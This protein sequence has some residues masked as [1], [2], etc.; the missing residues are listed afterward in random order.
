MKSIIPE[1]PNYAKELVVV[2]FLSVLFGMVE[3]VGWYRPIR[4]VIEF[5]GVPINSAQVRFV[6]AI[7]TPGQYLVQSF[8]QAEKTKQLEENYAAALSQ[9]SELEKLRQEN[10]ALRSL[11]ENSDRTL[12]SRKITSPLIS[13][14][15]PTI[16]A[17]VSEGV[18]V[19][20]MVTA[21]GVLLGLVEEV[22]EHQSSVALLSGRESSP[23]LAETEG[24]IQGIIEGNGR[25]VI[26][27]QV[28]RD[29][30]LE[31]GQRV[32]TLGQPGIPSGIFI[33]TIEEVITNQAAPVHSA[34]LSQ[35][36]SFYQM[37]VVEVW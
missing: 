7:A 21:R 22:S 1:T 2:I 15:K 37:P 12:E 28:P 36:V 32:V 25:R 19:G 11:L 29:Y 17:G 24:N 27:T 14:S 20:N 33:G 26:F 3:L 6:Q 30:E 34:I 9:L 16:A 10:Q 31:V 8:N 23:V 18:A 13:L 35:Q 5:I 4:G